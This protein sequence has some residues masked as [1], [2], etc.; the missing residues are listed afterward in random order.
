MSGLYPWQQA[1]WRKLQSL[2]NRPTQGLL[3][4][5]MK[6]IGKLELAIRY[7]RSLL[8]EHPLDDGQACEVC[9]ACH[10]FEQG[11]HPDFRMVQPE[12]DSE[13]TDAAKAEA[14]KAEAS[15]AGTGKKPSKQIS[16]EQIRGLADFLAM[17][18]HQGGRRVVVIHP[19]EAMNV[20]A[21]NALLKSLEEPPAGF[22]FILVTH[23]PQQI[24]PTLLS[25]CLTLGIAAPDAATATRWLA[26][27]G[28][29]QP[30]D[31]LAV[32][33][34]APLL[35]LRDAGEAALEARDKLLH[36]L[37]RP[38]QL[39]VFALA[40]ALQ[41]TELAIVVQ[42]VQQWCHD[43][44]LMK[45]TGQLRYHPAEAKLVRELVAPLDALALARLQRHLQ[46]VRKEAQHT[47]NPK[48]FL[49]SLFFTYLR[50]T[51]D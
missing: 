40:E 8:C 14:S 34:F 21:A 48:L 16:V 51:S 4:M 27:Q 44:V 46:Q 17:T 37:R 22:V 36:A 1:D 43:L 15:K 13:E 19:A 38:A 30:A 50:L 39:D 23:K 49:E 31:A 9:P 29:A 25:R 11:S 42:W 20:Y 41:K 32:A 12:A 26:E 33:G 3:F 2:R 45:L 5:G 6:G 18:A 35:A 7:A 24:L 47:L 28:V 10:W